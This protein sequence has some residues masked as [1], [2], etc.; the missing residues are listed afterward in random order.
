[1]ADDEIIAVPAAPL[2]TPTPPAQPRPPPSQSPPP[3]ASRLIGKS[4]TVAADASSSAGRRFLPVKMR[5]ANRLLQTDA[6]AQAEYDEQKLVI[7][8]AE[9]GLRQF[10]EVAVRGTLAAAQLGALFDIL[11]ERDYQK[12]E[13]IVE[14]GAEGAELLMLQRGGATASV[15]VEHEIA[16]VAESTTKILRQYAPGDYFGELALLSASP[17]AADVTATKDRTRCLVISRGDFEK[18][19]GPT[20]EVLGRVFEE[21][22]QAEA[23]KAQQAEWRE[24]LTLQ[25]PE[26]G[27]FVEMDFHVMLHVFSFLESPAEYG[28]VCAVSRNWNFLGRN[29]IV[30][31]ARC[32]LDLNASTVPAWCGSWYECYRDGRALRIGDCLEVRDKHN[33]WCTARVLA[34]LDPL[35]LLVALE[36][37]SEAWQ[38]WIHREAD[39]SRIRSLGQMPPGLGAGGGVDK[40]ALARLCEAA[41]KKL[42]GGSS[43]W[44]PPPVEGGDL[45][46]MY[47]RGAAGQGQASESPAGSSAQHEATSDGRVRVTVTEAWKRT[48]TLRREFR[49][50]WEIGD[51]VEGDISPRKDMR[52]FDQ[53]GVALAVAKPA[54]SSLNA[55]KS[56]VRDVAQAATLPAGSPHDRWAFRSSATS[57]PAAHPRSVGDILQVQIAEPPRM[58]KTASIPVELRRGV[59]CTARV[60][61][62][63]D[64]RRFLVQCEGWRHDGLI[65]LD[66][67]LDAHRIGELTA[68]RGP[69]GVGPDGIMQAATLNRLHRGILALMAQGKSRWAVPNPRP[70]VFWG[71]ATHV[72]KREVVPTAAAAASL[73]AAQGADRGG[74]ENL[75][76]PAAELYWN[77]EDEAAARLNLL[78]AK[79]T[80]VNSG[81]GWPPG[82]LLGLSM[83]PAPQDV[84]QGCNASITVYMDGAEHWCKEQG[85]ANEFRDCFE[86]WGLRQFLG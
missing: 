4:R 22:Q 8:S 10:L 72:A 52:M 6:I 19:V 9:P 23:A 37:W 16:G 66:A 15:P 3:N 64:Q 65:W 50:S 32:R 49:S 39:A 58:S 35:R 41:Q 76:G 27:P 17:R 68:D 69:C 59:W 11:T 71:G 40:M 7:Y 28:R 57:L 44:V 13:R 78:R 86:L 46:A 84:A 25:E 43:E 34:K 67:V 70:N 79:S 81:P 2:P 56:L 47:L 26:Q 74:V 30:W 14:R 73:R 24:A 48:Q 36:G 20:A 12:G 63:L 5:K 18:H 45:H 21:Q 85:I 1:M 62:R 75:P 53:H 29:E 33:L 38:F 83:Y 80:V 55:V 77:E 60:M 61:C 42:V 54:G 31:H 82:G 51:R